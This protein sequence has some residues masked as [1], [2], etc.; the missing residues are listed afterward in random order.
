MWELSIA[1]RFL[2][3]AMIY[4]GEI[5]EVSRKVPVMLAAALEQGNVFGAT[6][7][8]T[9]LNL[10]WLAADDPDRARE[11]AIEAVKGMAPR[12]I[13]SPALQRN[14]RPR[15]DRVIHGGY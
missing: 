1:H 15:T 11:E 9:R 4:R 14:A 13:P 10:I 5:A 7:L 2:F 12:R 8:R 6:D 3:S